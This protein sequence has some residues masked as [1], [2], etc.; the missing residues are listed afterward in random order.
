P[1]P[2]TAQTAPIATQQPYL[3]QQQI[4]QTRRNIPLMGKISGAQR[5]LWQEPQQVMMLNAFGPGDVLAVFGVV[6][7]NAA[8]KPALFGQLPMI[9]HFHY[10]ATAGE[11]YK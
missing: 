9:V 6:Y 2:A 11:Q 3:G 8:L 5:R 4:N 10:P 1:A 7:I